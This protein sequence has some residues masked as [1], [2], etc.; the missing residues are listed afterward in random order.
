M[1]APPPARPDSAPGGWLPVVLTRAVFGVEMAL[2]GVA[3]NRLRSAIT[4]IGVTIG[5]A[6]IVSLVGIGEG[7]RLAIVRQ[8]ESL[9]TNLIKIE[10]HHWRAELRPEDA[11]ALES[12]VPTISLAMPVV[13]A[14][15]QVKWRR[16]A[17]EVKIIGVSEDF[18]ALRQHRLLAGRFFSHLH[19]KERLRVAVLGFNVVDSLFQGRNPI[20][21]R[22]YID[23]QRFTVIGVL[24]P[25]G[26][27]MAD[28]IDDKIVLP[29]TSAQRLT[30]SYRVN[31]L[32]AQ[33]VSREAVDAAVV[34]ISRIYNKKLG[35]DKQQ[36]D[37]E[38]A[39]KMRGAY[40]LYSP[41]GRYYPRG[42]WGSSGSV[43]MEMPK[44]YEKDKGLGPET[45][46]SVTSLNELVQEAS[47]AN[48]VMT[49]MLG[50]IAGVSLLVGGLGIMNIMLVSV[51]ER[52]SEIGLRKAFGA[53]R[54][55]LIFQFLVEAFLLSAAGGLI[56]L[57]LGVAG[58][59]AIASYGIEAE[60]TW[61]ACW[62]AITSAL[63]VGLLF[64]VY[65]AYQA[66]GL[67]PVEALRQ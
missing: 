39:I 34:Q 55:D 44:P 41:Y 51:T 19:V 9:G 36:P 15:G 65:P 54:G 18:P 53:K 1:Q 23:G 33:G 11:R 49:L 35:L 52:T 59:R 42:G 46:L 5:V 66:S 61:N 43:R 26:T 7:A 21:Q 27:G 40:G 22:I 60:V 37:D 67:S 17:Q 29:L 57:L 62:V 25:K 13:K 4:V 28:D 63:A 16:R 58:C 8:F 31:E 38:K 64:G 6:S 10:S 20:G 47:Q 45:L 50:G 24:E 32:W 12:R 48:R 2:G 14:E 30:R 56:G 3:M